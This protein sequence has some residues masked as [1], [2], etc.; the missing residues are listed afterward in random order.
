MNFITLK[1]K[2]YL[3][4]EIVHKN[5]TTKFEIMPFDEGEYKKVT[6]E[7]ADRLENSINRKRVIQEALTSLSWEGII[8]IRNELR[9]KKV[10]I[11]QRR[12]CYELDIGKLP[13][14]ING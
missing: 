5:G 9:K 4:R 8:K 14:Y 10:K 1:G 12:G 6:D 11:K 13:L 7:I 2:K 3:I